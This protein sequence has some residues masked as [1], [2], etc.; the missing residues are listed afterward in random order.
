MT[1]QPARFKSN[2]VVEQFCAWHVLAKAHP[3]QHSRVSSAIICAVLVLAAPGAPADTVTL[4][5]VADTTLY[6]TTP[7]NNLGGAVQLI[8]GTTIGNAGQPFRN[9]ALLR[10]DVA[11]RVSA[12]ATITSVR[13]TVSMV[14]APITPANSTFELRR[15][16]VSWGEGNKN[17]SAGL[18][19]T[20][21][22]ATWISRFALLPQWAVPGGEPGTD[23]ATN[24]SDAV[25]MSSLGSYTF[26]SNS[27]LVADVQNWLDNTDANFGWMLLS[28]D[29]ATPGTARRFAS[30]ESPSN[31]PALFIDFAPPPVIVDAS[32]QSTNITFHFTVVAGYDYAVE[33]ADI[34]PATNWLTL[35]NFEAKIA[36]FEATITN[37]SQAD[38][39]RFYRLSRV[40]CNCR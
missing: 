4:L 23:F 18:P 13:L 27:N 38:P 30:R 7:D 2:C 32:L 26:L 3:M 14:K 5:P 15:L 33:Y 8:A 29:E 24:V 22:E 21:G 35:T 17:G 34:L 9:R 1:E 28:Q 25:F 39:A 31:A 11:G 40:P 10:F 6:E 20:S 19:A 37:S 36:D 16:L 12:G